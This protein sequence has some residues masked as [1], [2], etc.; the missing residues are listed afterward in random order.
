MP[1]VLTPLT[2]PLSVG[3]TIPAD[4]A[5]GIHAPDQASEQVNNIRAEAAIALRM[6]P[7]RRV[8]DAPR[9]TLPRRA[10]GTIL[11]SGS[12][13]NPIYFAARAPRG[14]PV[15]RHGPVSRSYSK[16]PLVAV[17]FCG[18]KGTGTLGHRDNPANSRDR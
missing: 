12:R 3:T 8:G 4:A 15:L 1:T 9:P 14:I 2:G 7:S 17:G 5:E 18:P 16:A 10:R 6:I 13:E 11:L